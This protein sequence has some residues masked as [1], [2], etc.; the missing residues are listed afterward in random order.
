MR[1]ADNLP[2]SCAFVM[3]SGNLNFLEPSGPLQAYNGT[4]L[5]FLIATDWSVG[6]TVIGPVA[7]KTGTIFYTITLLVFV[8]PTRSVW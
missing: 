8:A 6:P 4:A 3:K 1:K 5:P 7:H 2:P